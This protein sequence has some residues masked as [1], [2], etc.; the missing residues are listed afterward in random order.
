MRISSRLTVLCG[1]TTLAILP[2]QAATQAEKA[3]MKAVVIHAYG[4]MD[5][6]KLEAVPRPEPKE[7][8]ILIRVI[9]ASVNPVDAAIR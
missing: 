9:A 6:L 1:L 8:E 2:C 5:V 3:T 4:G 7:D